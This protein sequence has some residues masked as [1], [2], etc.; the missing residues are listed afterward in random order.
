MVMP[1]IAL[2]PDMS[3]VCSVG[4]TLVMTSKPTNIA[5]TKTYTLMRIVPVI[6]DTSHFRRA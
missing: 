1:E 2:E 6:A 5:S 4:G 3:G